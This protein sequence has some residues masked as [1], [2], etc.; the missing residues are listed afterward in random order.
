MM[1]GRL[2]G[3]AAAPQ[4]TSRAR[5]V[6]AEVWRPATVPERH[7]IDSG[8]FTGRVMPRLRFRAMAEEHSTFV[9]VA[10]PENGTTATA[11][12]SD[13]GGRDQSWHASCDHIA[14]TWST[15]G[16][17]GAIGRAQVTM[18][19]REHL[20]DHTLNLPANKPRRRRLFRR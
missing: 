7:P 5:S 20:R 11:Y 16:P 13:A 19:A 2:D 9:Q 4:N 10:D 8:A 17:R 3:I 18:A 12:H 1:A 15:T 6:W 14:C